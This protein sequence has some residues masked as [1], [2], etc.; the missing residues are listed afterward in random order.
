MIRG[1]ERGLWATGQLGPTER[2]LLI[3]GSTRLARIKQ[4]EP[5]PNEAPLTKTRPVEKQLKHG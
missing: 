2:L 5:P 3:K 1:I 4:K